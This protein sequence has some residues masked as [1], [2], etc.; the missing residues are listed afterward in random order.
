MQSS[1]AW[2]NHAWVDI[3]EAQLPLNDWGVLQGAII[4][5]RLRTCRLLPLDS[6]LH[7][8]RLRSNCQTIGINPQDLD[9]LPSVINECVDRNQK[10]FQNS[11]C[12]LVVLV[13]PGLS[14]PSAV[15]TIIVHVQPL[16]WPMLAHWHQHGQELVVA[17]FRNV[18]AACWSPQLK[19]RSRLHYYLADRQAEARAGKNAAAVLLSTAGFVTETS[20]ASV[21]VVDESGQLHCPPE[22]DVL[23]SISLARTLRLAHA[24]GITVIRQPISLDL[25][26]AAREI[27]LTG[28]SGCLWPACK[29]ED[30]V[31]SNATKLPVYRELR[32]RWIIDIGLDYVAQSAAQLQR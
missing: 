21:L 32:D 23:G 22:E 10:L 24:A 14:G 7:I 19:T 29:F 20:V 5:D 8:K 17:D 27:L 1:I 18:P 26:G 15:P 30:R 16:N 11:D 3:A 25:I 28:T 4:V 9:C 31:I 2:K 6:S 12:G 13:T